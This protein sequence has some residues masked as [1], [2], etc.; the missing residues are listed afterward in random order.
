MENGTMQC[1]RFLYFD[2]I[3]GISVYNI[4]WV[5]RFVILLCF[6]LP[7]A[8]LFV[9]LKNK[10]Y[11]PPKNYHLTQHGELIPVEPTTHL[12]RWFV[13]IAAWILL[14]ILVLEVLNTASLTVDCFTTGALPFQ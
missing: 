14:I 12:G 5:E 8:A 3:F 6:L 11:A 2:T 4:S 1:L 13:F 10:L 9:S 7:L